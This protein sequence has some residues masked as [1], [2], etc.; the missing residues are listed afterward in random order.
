M[1][2][3][4]VLIQI[5]GACECVTLHGKG[6]LKL[7]MELR[8][9]MRWGDYSGGPNVITGV[10]KR[11]LV[12][13]TRQ[14]RENQRNAVW[15]LDSGCWPWRQRKSLQREPALPTLENQAMI[16]LCCF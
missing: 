8:L 3:K 12:R 7:Q 11:T 15:G 1:A 14:K 10:L 4:D 5:P 6:E 9:L 2:P 16:N 13:K